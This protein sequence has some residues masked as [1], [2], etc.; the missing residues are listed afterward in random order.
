VN[1]SSLD[2]FA[3]VDSPAD[4]ADPE[5]EAL[6]KRP[7]WEQA[8]GSPLPLGVKWIE[9][10]Q[11]FN[12]AVHAEHAESVTLLLYSSADLVNPL[13]TFRFDFLHNKSGR[14]W[15]C[16]IPI[17]KIGEARYYAYSVS[18][19]T[20]PHLHSFDPQ[21][22]LLDPYTKCIFFPPGFD[23]ELAMREGPDAGRAPLGVLTGHRLT[24]DWKGD[25]SPRHESDAIVY[26]LHVK[27]FTK[28]PNSGI[29][30]SR[31]GTYAGLVE[32]IPYLRELGITVVE[33]MPIFQRDPQEGDYWGYMPL[34]FFAPHAQYA[35][36]DRDDE[37]HIEFRNMV[38]AFHEAGIG[39]VLDVVYN[40]TCEGDHRGPIYSFKGIG[41]ADYYMLSS[42]P[43]NPYANY[44]GTGNTLNFG[45]PHVRKMVM[46]SLRFWKQ[47]MHI[48][49]FRFDLA[50][51]FS[52]NADGSLNWGDA[53]I[54]SEIAADPELGR[55][56]LI[57]EPWDT[58][59]YQLGRGFPG[60]TWLQWN[61]RFRDDIRHFVK[62][63]PGMVPDLMRRI[64]GSDDLFPDSRADAYHAY[65]SVN[66][67][68]SHDG[69]TLYDLVSY[70]RKRNWQNGNDN[71]DGADDNYSWNCGQDGDDDVPSEV[72]ALRRK[73]V[74]NFCCL[75]FLSNGTPM[76]RA[77]DEFLNTQF[78][79]NNPYNQDNETGWLDW[80]QLRANA[81]VFRFFQSM[82]AFRKNHPSLSRSRFW[83]EDVSWYGVGPTVDL[84]YDSH[85]LAFCLHGASQGDEDIYVMINAYWEELEFHV[86]EGTAQ[87][88]KRIVDTALPSPD[89]FAD[90]G[91]PL[92]QTKC[93]VAP[94]SIV[95]LRRPK[96]SDV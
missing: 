89:D 11:A 58:A 77:G 86:Q 82:I 15:H 65:Q 88:W 95:V 41:A 17:T 91:V 51:V 87:E 93:T 62:S 18:G 38:K 81:D 44:S 34:N 27:G 69:F 64:Y 20:I 76:F 54:F 24:F 92:E 37:Q 53:P 23:R 12:F 5:A 45:Q 80:S 33:L 32:K 31:A 70:D 83:R 3:N 59:A 68:T 1:D 52:R 79:N 19:E 9:D 28:N 6:T 71:K 61:G 50:S 29:D 73:Q 14:I 43:A 85:S 30:P 22:I 48:D 46:D 26:E 16:R 78:G 7:T 60:M 36:T 56:H 72:R 47:E 75:L 66:F 57:A 42:D 39:V 8:E 25:R 49:G 84:S 55:L 96:K 90:C 35:S 94:R 4:T 74:K 2:V 21:K 40:H 13:L 63:D 10:E 67:V